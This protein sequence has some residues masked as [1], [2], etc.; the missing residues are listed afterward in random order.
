MALRCPASKPIGVARLPRHRFVIMQEGYAS[1]VRDPSRDAHGV[2]WDV[3]LADMRALDAY[4]EVGRGLYAKA[5]QPVL[6]VGGGSARA[7]VYLGRGR[8]GGRALPGYMEGVI[9]AARDWGLPDRYIGELEGH[10]ARGGPL[11]RLAP[12][13][14]LGKPAAGGVKVRPRFAT[15]FDRRD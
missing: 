7:L 6:K 11:A 8:S 10:L 2:L 4:E 13:P 9:A 5:I 15:P 14:A 3:G 12:E 1:V